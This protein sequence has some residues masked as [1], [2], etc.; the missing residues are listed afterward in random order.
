MNQPETKCRLSP[1][2]IEK[3]GASDLAKAIATIKEKIYPYSI[4]HQEDETDYPII[5]DIDTVVDTWH[6]PPVFSINQSEKTLILD[7]KTNSKQ[8]QQ[9]SETPDAPS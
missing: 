5:D 3:C 8:E 4:A 2:A 7:K 1:N 9:T 6:K